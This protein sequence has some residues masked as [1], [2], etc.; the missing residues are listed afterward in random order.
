MKSTTT[1]PRRS[2][3]VLFASLALSMAALLAGCDQ[4]SSIIQA[5][6]TVV[7]TPEVIRAWRNLHDGWQWNYTQFA[8][9]GLDCRSLTA[10]E[11]AKEGRMLKE[12]LT[13]DTYYQTIISCT[14][15]LQADREEKMAGGRKQTIG[16]QL[17][18]N[19]FIQ[20]GGDATKPQ[21]Q[22]QTRKLDF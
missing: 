19:W 11:K 9:T 15:H 4:A 22:S 16:R 1:S 14:Y 3:H 13:V 17:T 18:E 2:A 7:P 10:E 21:W 20:P 6:P 5:K 12:G 8:V